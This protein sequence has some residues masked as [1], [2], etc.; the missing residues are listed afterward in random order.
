MLTPARPVARGQ[1]ELVPPEPFTNNAFQVMSLAH[2]LRINS[3][4]RLPN[5]PKNYAVCRIF[6]RA[7]GCEANFLDT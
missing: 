2:A 6:V 5:K 3:R 7:C 1:A 4:R